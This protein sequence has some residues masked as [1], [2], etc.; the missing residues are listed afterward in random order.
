MQF[1]LLFPPCRL[2]IFLAFSLQIGFFDDKIGPVTVA[3]VVELA[4]LVITVS[5]LHDVFFH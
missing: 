5:A 1:L 4:L 3:L 2:T